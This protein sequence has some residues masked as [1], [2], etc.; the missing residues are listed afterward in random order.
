MKVPSLALQEAARAH[1]AVLLQYPT[2]QHRYPHL[3][4]AFTFLNQGWILGPR[5]HGVRR[6]LLKL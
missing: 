3:P 6:V 4:I 5:T 2:E 1:G